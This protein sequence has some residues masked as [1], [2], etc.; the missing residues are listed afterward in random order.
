MKGKI[1]QWLLHTYTLKCNL[2]I[3]FASESITS[4]CA[5][6]TRSMISF[7][8]I[9]NFFYDHQTILLLN[10]FSF[11]YNSSLVT[12]NELPKEEIATDHFVI[13]LLFFSTVFFDSCSF[14]LWPNFT[15]WDIIRWIFS[16][17][18]HAGTWFRSN[19]HF[20]WYV[21]VQFTL[22]LNQSIFNWWAERCCDTLFM[23]E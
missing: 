5:V 17:C 7:H 11:E 19:C 10:Y 3:L 15:H 23:V 16:S 21:G 14:F 9:Y 6:K 13:I 22:Q 2:C 12:T 18:L 20:H 8:P 1:F 4:C